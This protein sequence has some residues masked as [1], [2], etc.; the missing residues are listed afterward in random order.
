MPDETPFERTFRAL[1][2]S[3]PFPWQIELHRR[4]VAGEWERLSSCDIPTGLGK[5]AIIPIWLI[6]LAD[7]GDDVP[8][9]LVYVVN[10]RTVV[11]QATAEAERMRNEL[12]EPEGGPTP[13]VKALRDR[14][15][16]L[17]A[18]DFGSES[19][20]LAI[21]TLR[22]QFADNREWSADPARPAII[23]GTVDMIGSR[24]LFGGYG[25]GFKTKPLHAGF[26]GQDALLVHDKAHLEP[27]LQKLIEAVRDE[28][29]NEPA[30]LGEAKRLKVMALTA[31]PRGG[32]ALQ[33]SEADRTHPVVKKRIEARKS[34]HLH[35]YDDEKKLP[36]R[37]AEFALAHK[38]SKR[39]V[40]VFA[41]TVEAVE[42]VVEK[43]KKEGQT[44][45]E[46]LTGTLRGKERDGLV[47]KSVFQRFLPGADPGME[48]AYLVCTSAGEV[49]INISSD[50]LVCDLTTFESMAQRFGR[51]NRF[52]GRDDTRID[53]LYP[54]HFEE[55]ELDDR[56]AKTL[57]LL[58][59]LN[60]D[61][62]PAALGD[63][64]PKDREEAYSP[65]P[66]YQLTSDV[67][68]DAWALT[69]I[70][71]D[72]P[73]RP[74]VGP[75][76]HGLTDREPPVTHVAWRKEVEIIGPEL[77]GRYD[78]KRLLEAYPLKPQEWLRD[79]S[80][81][82][83]KQLELIAKRRPDAWAWLLDDDGSVEPLT[84]Q[85]LADKDRKDRIDDRT[86]LLPPSAGGL[87]EGFLSGEST[88]AD[89]VADDWYDEQGQ[90]R[91]KR[92]R[93]NDPVPSAPKEMRLILTIDTDPDADDREDAEEAPSEEG[94]A[95]AETSAPDRES[96]DRFWYWYV[97]PRSSD[98]DMSRTARGAILWH[99]H[100]EDVTENTRKIIRKL[101]L[102]SEVK[103]ALP[104][105]AEWHDLGK[106]RPQWQKSI[107]NRDPN[108]LLA[109]SGTN[110]AG[111]AGRRIDF[112]TDYRHEFGSMLDARAMLREESD[113]VRNLILHLI[114]AHHGR[115]RPHFDQDEAFDLKPPR[116]DGSNQV[117]AEV[118]RRFARLQR[119]FGRWGL[120][121]LESL[122]RAADYSASAMPSATVEVKP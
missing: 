116:G 11:D 120:A 45:V 54:K 23:V 44:Q 70:R 18:L 15:A 63:L 105:A 108:L 74:P 9:R 119:Q 86:V 83:F 13:E 114:A 118:P 49:G 60:E 29:R 64:N 88:W 73:G 76:L 121:Y 71:G 22:G 38:D 84:L 31:T 59:E 75:Y 102:P 20:P 77:R 107:G 89:D 36:E 66:E 78:P 94:L 32:D 93:S 115:G 62:S 65:E 21:S 67:L 104:R 96:S 69:S 90:K 41:R 47:K 79:R 52:G 10:R 19:P 39:T 25:L 3:G 14:L 109:K 82:V 4:L 35:E 33:L 24:L 111:R 43:L 28:Q 61:G 85:E 12:K 103:E 48:S 30:P 56:R 58:R 37:L 92:W 110:K 34:L 6:A 17:C 68:F 46:P 53:V 26:L 117:A 100:T 87:E 80:S 7:R 40:L 101:R 122:L 91:R 95:V 42:K 98:D 55:G 57:A 99:V 106:D 113:D 50:H 1:T 27:A 2:G 51:V 97:K 16:S 5:T 8:R 112:E 81:R 72:L